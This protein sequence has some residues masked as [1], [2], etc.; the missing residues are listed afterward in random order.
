VGEAGLREATSPNHLI[1]KFIY[2]FLKILLLLLLQKSPV[3]VI[4]LVYI[5]LKL[6]VGALE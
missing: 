6:A 2:I 4:S 3:V 1:N 5:L